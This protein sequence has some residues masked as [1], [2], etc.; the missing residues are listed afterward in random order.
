MPLVLLFI[1]LQFG[2][3][4]AYCRVFSY[5]SGNGVVYAAATGGTPD[6]TY[7]WT[8]LQTGNSEDNTTWG[9]LNPGN[10]QI[11]VTDDN[12]CILTDVITID[13]LNPIADFTLTSP[14]FSSNYVGNAIVNVH[15]VNQSSNYSNPIDP[16]ADTTF[17]WSFGIAEWIKLQRRIQ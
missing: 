9:G 13:S 4:P 2:Y 17:F 14:E 12:G 6:Y 10:Y 3:E 8:N 15:F 11:T 16:N 7:L 5:Q 1:L